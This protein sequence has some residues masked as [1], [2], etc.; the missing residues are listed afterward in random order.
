MTL[1]CLPKHEGKTRG[2]VAHGEILAKEKSGNCQRCST[3]EQ[4]CPGG[5]LVTFI[6]AKIKIGSRIRARL[7][8]T[9]SLVG[10]ITGDQDC[11]SQSRRQSYTSPRLRCLGLE[12]S[13]EN[14]ISY[15]NHGINKKYP[16][17]F[18]FLFRLWT[19]QVYMI[20]ERPK[21]FCR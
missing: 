11:S 15:H 12:S 10:G 16:S 7:F 13:D 19:Y 4:K 14:A 6:V 18:G 17:V 9:S 2:N 5:V 8:N 21:Q 20:L 1:I 3:T